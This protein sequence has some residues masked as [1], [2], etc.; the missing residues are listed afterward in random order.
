ME[1][2]KSLLEKIIDRVV[3]NLR[4]F[5]QIYGIGGVVND[6]FQSAKAINIFKETASWGTG[7]SN[8]EIKSA[9]FAAAPEI[10]ALDA[11]GKAA[12]VLKMGIGWVRSL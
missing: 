1:E 8:F 5:E 4:Q 3:D 2:E 6:T 7:L 10:G 9:S 12:G 11:M